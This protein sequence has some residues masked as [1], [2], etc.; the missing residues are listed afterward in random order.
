MK[1]FFLAIFAA[2][3]GV[4]S[5]VVVHCGFMSVEAESGAMLPTLAPGQKTLVYLLADRDRLQEGDIV[6]YKQPYYVADGDNGILLRR[7]ESI[8]EDEMVLSCDAGVTAEQEITVK[9]ED[10][11]GKAILF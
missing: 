10:I 5:A 6:A 9:Q 4:C 2:L 11:L 1:K 3:L 8:D 7:I